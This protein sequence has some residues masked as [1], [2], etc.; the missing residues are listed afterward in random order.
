MKKIIFVRPWN[1]QACGSYCEVFIM[2][3]RSL[4]C[5]RER[6]CLDPVL[7]SCLFLSYSFQQHRNQRNQWPF[8]L[9][10]ASALY[11]LLFNG[12]PAVLQRRQ[13]DRRW[14]GHCDEIC[15]HVRLTALFYFQHGFL[16]EENK[17]E[18][19]LCGTGTLPF[20]L[21]LFP[22]RRCHGVRDYFHTRLVEL[23]CTILSIFEFCLHFQM[24]TLWTTSVLGMPYLQPL[25]KD[26]WIL[27]VDWREDRGLEGVVFFF[28]VSPSRLLFPKIF[29]DTNQLV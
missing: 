15:R 26:C 19:D 29:Q 13:E 22:P 10:L 9:R 27:N 16:G 28:F 12:E 24:C 23:F 1:E 21:L 6:S 11:A 8:W 17:K 2:M 25:Q 20:F 4:V 3:W 5:V 18:D 7:T 14:D